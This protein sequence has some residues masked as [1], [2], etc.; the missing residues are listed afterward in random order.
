MQMSK[1]YLI[2]LLNYVSK[3]YGL[4]EKIKALKDARSNT[5]I[6]TPAISMVVLIGFMLKIRSFNQLDD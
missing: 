1:S 2:T 3:V 6:S 4:G 5:K